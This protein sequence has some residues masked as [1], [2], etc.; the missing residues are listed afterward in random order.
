M[1]IKY[2][3]EENGKPQKFL[4]FL[5]LIR[6]ENYDIVIDVYSKIT[7]GIISKFSGAPVRISYHKWYTTHFY[8]RTFNRLRKPHTNAGLA[9][10]NRML[11]LQ[12]LSE[13]FPLEQKP[14]IYLSQ[15]E[16]SK[17]KKQLQDAGISPE[18]PLLMIGVL[19]S[20][21]EK[22]Y[23]TAYM[24][25]LLDVIAKNSS[26]EFLFNY[27]PKQKLAVDKIYNFCAPSTRNRIHLEVFGKSLREFL[28][29]TAQCDALIGNEGGAINMAKALEVP[30]FAI[31]SPQIAKEAW[32]IYEDER[33][34]SV[35]LND[36]E[37]GVF[38]GKKVSPDLYQDFNPD[39]IS[40][41]LLKYLKDIKLA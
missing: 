30:T 29:L 34:Q 14:K 4:N 21:K 33:N 27:I 37:P 38:T 39:Y 1:I 8:T 11:L 7:T 26:A 16:T 35:H 12:A 36:F 20:S 31:F 18:K 17:A 13:E 41:V 3:P 6:N 5:K 23:P 25:K 28:A 24:A 9:I 2:D 22:T 19:G 10:E 40:P 15:E 32:A